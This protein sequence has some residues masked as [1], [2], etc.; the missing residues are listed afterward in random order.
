MREPLF[1][2]SANVKQPQRPEDPIASV[3]ELVYEDSEY[4]IW[5]DG[6]PRATA[7]GQF[8]GEYGCD[9]REVRCLRDYIRIFTRQEV[10]DSAGRRDY[11]EHKMFEC[12]IGFYPARAGYG[13]DGYYFDESKQPVPQSMLASF[14]APT[15]V[16]EDWHPP[17]HYAG[18][19]F[20]AKSHPEAIPVRLCFVG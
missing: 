10:W 9:F 18:Y 2:Q 14:E 7:M 16:P 3:C 6:V 5:D 15:T 19:E 4:G 17:E 1:T 12:K 13:P 11:F 20:V 8:A